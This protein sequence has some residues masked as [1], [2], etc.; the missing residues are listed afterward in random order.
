MQSEIEDPLYILKEAWG[1]DLSNPIQE[2]NWQKLRKEAEFGFNARNA[3]EDDW[4]I[5]QC[6]ESFSMR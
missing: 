2:I 4:I 1:T 3:M 6:P 5:V